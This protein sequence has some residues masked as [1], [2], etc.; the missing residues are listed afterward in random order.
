MSTVTPP[1]EAEA[2]EGNVTVEA[3]VRV[4][5][6]TVDK[7]DDVRKSSGKSVVVVVVVMV[8]VMTSGDEVKVQCCFRS[9]ETIRTFRDGELRTATSTFTQLLSSK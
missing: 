2:E 8:M 1:P 7:V 4:C 5:Q 6:A 3:A 9:T